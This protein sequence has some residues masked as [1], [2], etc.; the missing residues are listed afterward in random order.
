MKK[1]II[2]IILF[3]LLV[4]VMD[5]AYGKVI[6]E[7]RAACHGGAVQKEIYAADSVTADVLIFGSSRGR[8]RYVPDIIEDSLGMSCF[9]CGYN[10]MGG[11]YHYGMISMILER[12]T[13]K[14]VIYDILPV[15]D[16]GTR[17]DN[18]IFLNQLRPF[19]GRNTT[20]DSIFSDYDS[21]EPIKMIAQTYRY[22][23]KFLETLACCRDSEIA[24][25][26]YTINTNTMK[27][28]VPVEIAT[29]YDVDSLK[30]KYLEKF[31][32]E[33]SSKTELIVCASPRY[34]YTHT[35]DD[36]DSVIKVCKKYNVP[37]INHYTDK[38]YINDISLFQDATHLNYK[39]ATKWTSELCSIIKNL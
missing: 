2:R 24:K 13:P 15:L 17:D 4:G 11:I 14:L 38:S 29:H 18:V 36:F 33:V 6:E 1:F 34:G 21:T 37:F 8:E 27:Q 26:G 23:S 22:H 9:N 35:G 39:G 30:F 19:Y 10:G 25:S 5:F 28:H 16:I 31:I 3:L 20:I 32:K 12:Y 7:M